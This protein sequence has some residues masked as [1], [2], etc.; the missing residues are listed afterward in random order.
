MKR[1]DIP[2]E[3]PVIKAVWYQQN[4]KIGQWNGTESP[5]EDLHKY[6][7]LNFDKGAKAVK[8]RRERLFNK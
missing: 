5:E 1:L 7:Q 8:G 6:V 4:K 3:S 2:L